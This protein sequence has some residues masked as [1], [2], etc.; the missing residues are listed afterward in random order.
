MMPTYD[1]NLIESF[2]EET[3][4]NTPLPVYQIDW[5]NNRLLNRKVTGHDAVSQN[6]KVIT[7]VEHQEH[8]VMPDWFGLA[9]KDLYGMP[10]SYVKACLELKLKEAISPYQI[11]KRLYD[12]EIFDID[13]VSIGVRC[14]MELVDGSIMD[15]E[16]EVKL[17]V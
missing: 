2:N 13:S 8:Q 16:L 1:Q 17:N 3:T 12:F 5:E 14:K 15:E 7:S 11:V 10:R 4:D 9:M 6:I